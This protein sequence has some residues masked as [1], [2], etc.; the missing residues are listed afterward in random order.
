ME[1][2]YNMTKAIM[3]SAIE[4]SKAASIDV[5]EAENP[6]TNAGPVHATPT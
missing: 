6:A 1:A 3:Q 5:T 4:V 2:D